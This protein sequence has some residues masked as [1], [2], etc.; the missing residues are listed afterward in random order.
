MPINQIRNIS[1]VVR[2]P[3][4]VVHHFSPVV[5]ADLFPIG[6]DY[7]KFHNSASDPGVV[8]YKT[9]IEKTFNHKKIIFSVD[10]WD[11]TKGIVDRLNAFEFF[12][13]QR[14]EW[15]ENI[16]FVLNVV[17]S[18]DEIQSYNEQKRQLEENLW[19]VPFLVP[20]Y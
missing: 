3:H 16:S 13:G 10:R 19:P 11:Y 2:Q 18:R 15:K 1:F 6:V 8:D 14:P 9:E 17:P 20:A 12:L 7:N 4:S 5:R